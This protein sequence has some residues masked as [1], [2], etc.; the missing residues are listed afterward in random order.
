VSAA[1][2]V[3]AMRLCVQGDSRGIE[4]LMGRY[5]GR[6][7]RI[8]YLILGERDLA[9]DVAQESFVRAWASLRT[10]RIP[11]HFLPWFLQIVINNAR[12]QMRTQARHAVVRFDTLADERALDILD[13]THD[14]DI[15]AERR[16]VR[17]ALWVALAQL[18]PRQR[19][20]VVLRYY[21]GD[22]ATTIAAIVGC[23][24]DAARQRIHD[25]LRALERIISHHMPWLAETY[26][27]EEDSHA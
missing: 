6:A 24:P 23:R 11:M 5:H 21:N 10:G 17:A 2:D 3:T 13:A 8:A 20:A 4:Q 1:E 7:L 27:R 14:P 19:E 15:Y 25:G 22:D 12:M 16:E 18:T 9:E 26:L